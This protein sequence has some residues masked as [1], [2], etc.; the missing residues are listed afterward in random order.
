MPN[1]PP[2]VAARPGSVTGAVRTV[3][4]PVSQTTSAHLERKYRPVSAHGVVHGTIGVVTAARIFPRISLVAR[5]HV[6]FKR[7]CTCCCLP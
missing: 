2:G 6:D 4:G 5:R 3:I 1:A 7:V